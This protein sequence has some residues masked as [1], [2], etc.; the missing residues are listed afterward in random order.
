M[1]P[2]KR[3]V[4]KMVGV[5]EMKRPSLDR[6]D[7]IKNKRIRWQRMWDEVGN[8]YGLTKPVRWWQFWRWF[9]GR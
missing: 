8:F 3:P 4:P 7:R 9:R 5:L 1:G 6:Y 2:A